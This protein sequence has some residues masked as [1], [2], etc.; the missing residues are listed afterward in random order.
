MNE[1]KLTINAFTLVVMLFSAIMFFFTLVIP[2]ISD[3]T[4][5]NDYYRIEGT[6]YAIVYSD[7]KENGIYE[8]PQQTCV[9]KLEGSFGHDWGIALEEPYLYVNEYTY[10]DMG[11][12]HSDLVRID[13]TTFRKDVLFKDAILR[14]RCASGELVCITGYPMPSTFP[15]TNS[16]SNLYNMAAGIADGGDGSSR[17]VYLDPATSETLYELPFDGAEDGFD[18]AYIDRT[19]DDVR[20]EAQP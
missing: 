1:S 19:L 9:L 7:R 4:A 5:V 12:I 6:D 8:G 15:D 2:S 16:M 13:L 3:W 14:G 10:T 11:L 18:E 20:G 17:V